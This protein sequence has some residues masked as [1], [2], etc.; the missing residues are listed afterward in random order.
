MLVADLR[1]DLVQT[2]LAAHRDLAPARRG[3]VF[4]RCSPRPVA[5]SMPTACP[6]NGGGSRCGSTCAMSGS[7][8]NCRSRSRASRTANG[9]RWSRRFIAEHARRFGHGD[10]GAPVEIVSFAVTATGLIDTPELPRPPQGGP[11]RRR[12]REAAPAGLFRG[13]R[14]REALAG[15]SARCG[16]A[17][18]CL[19]AT[20]SPGRQS[21]R[22]SRRRRCFIRATAPMS[23]RSAAWSSKSA[24]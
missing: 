18:R 5:C 8:T 10:P 6:T 7:R 1:H 11:S 4:E 24:H 22:K 12:K 2:R 14:R 16:G 20:R 21:S 15:P 17:R 9:R 13:R 23:M 3:A 19:P